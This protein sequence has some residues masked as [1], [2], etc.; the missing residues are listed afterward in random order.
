MDGCEH[1]ETGY[2]QLTQKGSELGTG[3]NSIVMN[4]NFAVTGVLMIAFALGLARNIGGRNLSKIGTTLLLAAGICEAVVA[5][6]PCDPGCPAAPGSF[7]QNVHL[8]I[9]LVFFSSIAFAP[10]LVGIGLGGDQFWQP[11]GSYSKSTGIASVGF[12][13]V[14]SIGVLGSVPL[15]GL[16]ER[17]FLA[18][19]F[20]WIELMGIRMLSGITKQ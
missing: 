3:Q 1:S 10:L 20:L 17:V 12:G 2:N 5:G 11:Y 8:G 14:F 9:A 4:V 15:I 18:F 7:S 19:P 6:F 13:A 16:L